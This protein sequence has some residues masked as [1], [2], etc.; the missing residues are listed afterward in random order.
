MLASRLQLCRLAA[1][2]WHS[3][4]AR[5]PGPLPAPHPPGARRSNGVSNPPP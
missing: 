2:A 3:R 5:I 1:P 4:R